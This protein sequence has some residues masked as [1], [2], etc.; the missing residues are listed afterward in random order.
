MHSC[1]VH[2][3]IALIFEVIIIVALTCPKDNAATCAITVYVSMENI[4]Q[5][6]STNYL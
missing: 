3:Q 6:D 4:T 2:W 1:C 5:W